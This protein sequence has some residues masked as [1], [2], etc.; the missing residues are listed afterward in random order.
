MFLLLAWT[1]PPASRPSSRRAAKGEL[2]C[3]PVSRAKATELLGTMLGGY[4]VA[5]PWIDLLADGEVGTVR[6]RPFWRR[7]LVR[8]LP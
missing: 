4:N 5:F 1:M 7:L 3:G 8:L 6:R 2:A